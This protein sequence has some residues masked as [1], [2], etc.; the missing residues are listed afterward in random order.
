MKVH[1]VAHYEYG[2]R[3]HS[4]MREK[5]FPTRWEAEKFCE[6]WRRDHW[7]FGGAAW[8]ESITE[9]RPITANDVLAAAVIKKILRYQQYDEENFNF[10]R[11][12]ETNQRD[13][14]LSQ[15]RP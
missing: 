2:S 5:E 1:H 14:R 13:K 6:E 10:E 9:P 7:Y 4:E 8:A 15:R 3:P 12:L 11:V